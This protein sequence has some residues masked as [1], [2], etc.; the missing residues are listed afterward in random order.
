MKREYNVEWDGGAI[1]A[2]QSYSIFVLLGLTQTL[3]DNNLM[4]MRLNRYFY[5]CLDPTHLCQTNFEIDPPRHNINTLIYLIT[6][7]R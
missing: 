5:T 3:I 1:K 7:S 4:L 2:E 6:F